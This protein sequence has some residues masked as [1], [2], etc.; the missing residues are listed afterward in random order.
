MTRSSARSRRAGLAGTALALFLG[1]GCGEA[2]QQTVR[3]PNV[4]VF[5]IDDLGWTDLGAYGSTFYETPH[6]DRLAAEGMRFTQFYAAS[7][8]CSPTRVSLMTG[9]HPARVGITN[10]I[11]GEQAGPLLQAPYL[12]ALPLDEV[13]LGE[14][15]YPG[16]KAAAPERTSR[17]P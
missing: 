4:V 16:R 7:S 5:F 14:A 11:G 9:R 12:R 1:S 3:P 8:V 10:W 13:T 17:T 6:I 2:P 15:M